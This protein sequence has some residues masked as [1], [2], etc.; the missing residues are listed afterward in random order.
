[1]ILIFLKTGKRSVSKIRTMTMTNV[2]TSSS[3]VN[4]MMMMN[5]SRAVLS[6]SSHN[7]ASGDGIPLTSTEDALVMLNKRGSQHRVVNMSNVL[8]GNQVNSQNNG[9]LKECVAVRYKSNYVTIPE[10]RTS[11]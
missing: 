10:R 6:G 7:V 8:R 3:N 9:S 1:M 4:L 11:M 5:S 2:S